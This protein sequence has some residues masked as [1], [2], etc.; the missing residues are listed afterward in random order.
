VRNGVISQEQGIGSKFRQ[1]EFQLC[2][3]AEAVR[4]EEDAVKGAGQAG[5]N[6]G[7]VAADER[8]KLA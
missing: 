8:Y 2:R 3:G 5:N 6:L 4:V 1:Q 7:S